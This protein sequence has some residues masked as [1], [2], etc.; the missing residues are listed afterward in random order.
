MLVL[1]EPW[2]QHFPPRSGARSAAARRRAA[3]FAAGF[4]VVVF[5]W[6]CVFVAG[7]RS[8][9]FYGFMF[10]AGGGCFLCFLLPGGGRFGVLWFCV[11]FA[12]GGFMVL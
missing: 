1:S 2:P 4:G 3:I 8:L 6:F 11:F 5:L 12:G 7:G 9:G 10:F